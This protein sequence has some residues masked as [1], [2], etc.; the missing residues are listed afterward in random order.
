MTLAVRLFERAAQAGLPPAQERLAMM[1]D[2]GIT[3]PRDPKLAM[4]WYERAAQGGNI[5]AMHNLATLLAS[6][7]AGKPDYA[8]ALRWYSEAAEAGL[9]DSQFNMG[10]LLARGVGAKP[11]P[12]RAYKWFALA[13]AQGDADA[14]KKRD[15]MAGRLPASE[16]G[17]AKAAI[18]QWRP[19][20]ADPVAN[21]IPLPANGQTAALDRSLGNRS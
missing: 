5:R 21:E 17:S 15:E 2:K 9:R 3:V 4:T 18:E 16:I 20:A 13:A 7:S 10:I 8:A 14:A 12:A 1:H 6:G 11:D 19:R